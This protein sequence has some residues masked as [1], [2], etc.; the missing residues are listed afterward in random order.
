MRIELETTSTR[1]KHSRCILG[2][3]LYP[4]LPLYDIDEAYWEGDVFVARLLEDL[5]AEGQTRVSLVSLHI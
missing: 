1:A 2:E 5:S 4:I 3:L